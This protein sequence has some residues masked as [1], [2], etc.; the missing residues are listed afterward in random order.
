MQLTSCKIISSEDLRH[1]QLRPDYL[2]D[3]V[4]QG[5]LI[6]NLQ[7]FISAA[8]SR[9]EALDHVLLCGPPGLGK[10]TLAHILSKELRV[11]FRTTS[12]PLLNKAGDLAAILTSLNEKDVLFIDEIHRLNHCIEEILYPAMEDFCLDVL[13]GGGPST[14]TLRIDLPPFTLI[15]ATTRIGLLSHPLR[16]RFGI[17]IYLEFYS[18]EELIKI[19]KRGATSLSITI[20][21]SAAQEI[22]LRARGTPRLALRLL[23][24]VRDFVEVK[25]QSIQ[26][27]YESVQYALSQLGINKIGLTTLD[28]RYLK[29]LFNTSRPVGIETLSIALSEDVRNI[30]DTIEPYLIKISFIHRSSRGRILTNQAQEYLKSLFA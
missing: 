22:A 12:G 27:M 24:R 29:F 16:E 18:C 25:D 28:I 4:G 7:V 11:S 20:H 23:R 19:I 1:I 8:R 9:N 17:P 15:G 26:I 14:R 30:E 2:D 21:D 6:N 3:F 5:E 13:V 10:T